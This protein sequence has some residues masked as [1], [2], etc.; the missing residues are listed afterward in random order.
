MDGAGIF[1]RM[2]DD[3]AE[4]LLRKLL[5]TLRPQN[6]GD[7]DQNTMGEGAPCKFFR[8]GCCSARWLMRAS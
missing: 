1:S 8:R 4:L 7:A 2:F 3:R 5:Q 6:Q